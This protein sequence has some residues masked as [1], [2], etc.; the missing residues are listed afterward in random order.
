MAE[1]TLT[2]YF[3]FGKRVI[4]LPLFCDQLD[5]GQR[6]EETGPGLHFKP[7]HVTEEE[8]LVGI[9][10]LLRDELLGRRMRSISTRMQVSNSQM[11]AAELVENVA[12][13]YCNSK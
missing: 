4:V 8:L 3:Y 13:K 7:Y 1:T 2:E 12:V 5:N 10:R 6:M 9:E 11:R